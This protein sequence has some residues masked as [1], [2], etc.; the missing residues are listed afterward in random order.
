MRSYLLIRKNN[1][2]EYENIDWG[3]IK[4][5][6]IIPTHIFFQ[7]KMLLMMKSEQALASLGPEAKFR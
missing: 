5:Q 1:N 4:K 3:Q 7:R 6:R 2:G